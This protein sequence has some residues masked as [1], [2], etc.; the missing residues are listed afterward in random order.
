VKI[1][2]I[3]LSLFIF[4]F[5]S[6]VGSYGQHM[7]FSA[8]S[9]SKNLALK[10]VVNEYEILE[11]D[12]K[13]LKTLKSNNGSLSLELDLGKRRTWVIELEESNVLSPNTTYRLLR[14]KAELK[15]PKPEIHTYRGYL[16]NDYKSKVAVTISD[17]HLSIHVSNSQGTQIL[18]PLNI[19]DRSA[20]PTKYMLYDAKDINEANTYT[21]KKSELISEISQKTNS[22]ANKVLACYDVELAIAVDYQMYV[23]EGSNIGNVLTALASIYN[24]VSQD[25]DNEFNHQ[26]NIRIKEVVIAS[27]SLCDP[28][29]QTTNVGDALNEIGKWG[30]GG[31]FNETYDIGIYWT[32][33]VY[34]DNFAGLAHQDQ[35][36]GPQRYIAVRK[37]TSNNQAL[38]V[39]MSHEIG[40]SFGA[41]HNYEIGSSC[42]SNPGRSPRIMDPVVNPLSLG[43]TNGT[44]SC[45]LNTRA[46]INAKIVSASCL[47]AC[48]T[49]TC[50]SI[51]NLN[52][53]NVSQNGISAS[54]TGSAGSYLV[55]L[56]KE[57]SNN[58]IHSTTTSS[59][60]ITINA[61]L[62][63]CE[64][65]QLSVKSLCGG[66]NNPAA[67]T[68]LVEINGGTQIE[69]LYVEPK[70]CDNGAY[71]LE[72]VVAYQNTVPG[73][74]RVVANGNMQIFS[75]TSSPQTVTLIGLNTGNNTNASLEAYGTSKSDLACRGTAIY[76]EP[77]SDCEIVICEN[78]NTCKLPYEWTATSTNNT[79][80]SENFEWKFA[81]EDRLILNYQASNNAT[82]D[83]TINGTCAAYFD[84]DIFMNTTYT[85]SI[86]LISKAYDLTN[87][88]NVTL[89]LDY[90]FHK[91]DEGKPIQ[92]SSEFSIDLFNGSTWTNVMFDNN[93][94]CPWNDVWQNVCT[95]NFIMD[96]TNFISSDFRV[97]LNYTDGNSGDWTGMIMVDN[98]KISGV[99]LSVLELKI[100]DFQGKLRASEIDLDWEIEKD[101]NFSHY[102]I[103]KS[104]DGQE[105][106]VLQELDY[107]SQYI[108]SRPFNGP[109]YY[110]L[111]IYDND[112]N[113]VASDMIMVENH[114]EDLVSLYP[115]PTNTEQ[116]TL[117]NTTDTYY[118]QLRIFG[119]DGREIQHLSLNKQAHT[120]LDLTGLREGIYLIQISN[121]NASKTL[122]L[123][124]L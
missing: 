98:F 104:A 91:F 115:N 121:G 68:Q 90:N 24:L 62:N 89:E 114:R 44:L 42:A 41:G 25:F 6:S 60:S 95:T 124:K 110:K 120:N 38:R 61:N 5:M 75:Y 108:D 107:G 31:G 84:D 74:F 34:D 19:Y 10:E 97:R 29:S 101:D 65:Y 99:Q 53:S 67:I 96:V 39:M 30:E 52:V 86:S 82:T 73:G 81:D 27:C 50:S 56:R 71:D 3:S 4:S 33:K 59:N 105:F 85:G 109:N 18:E 58:Y 17:N 46:V 1:F 40:H 66:S 15:I 72:V 83:K 119:I 92:N 12:L 32:S 22:N 76:S 63:Y 57:G 106:S 79:V 16:A 55:R 2:K 118:D 28:W 49:V 94:F 77:N 9:E 103:E 51:I 87:L 8:S 123:V 26:L 111:K 112:G 13:D 45:D 80:F 93:D 43:W 11:L 70:N 36:C 64:Q 47:D 23:S 48:A 117:V 88:A 78:F 116:V 20:V 21:C 54:W 102:V 7:K 113:H 14:E 35:I 69:I 37:Y 100:L 122:R